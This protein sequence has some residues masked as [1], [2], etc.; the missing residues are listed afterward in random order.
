MIVGIC[1]QVQAVFT[2][3]YGVWSEHMIDADDIRNKRND[4]PIGLVVFYFV[5]DL[6]ALILLLILFYILS[7]E[8]L[9]LYQHKRMKRDKRKSQNGV[10]FGDDGDEESDS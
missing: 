2:F 10:L 4:H 9:H 7:D 3:R 8:V 1:W 5:A 6:I